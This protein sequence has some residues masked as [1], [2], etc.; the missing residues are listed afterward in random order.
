MK[1]EE[2]YEVI[3]GSVHTLFQDIIPELIWKY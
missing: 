3:T 1:G 2:D